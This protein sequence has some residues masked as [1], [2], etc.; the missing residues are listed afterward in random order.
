[1]CLDDM[2]DACSI[3]RII[4]RFI[5]VCDLEE[6]GFSNTDPK[7]RGR[8]SYSPN[9]LAKLFMF[10]YEEG[11]RS[12][13]R[14]EKACRTNTEV[15]W[16]VGGLAPD[17]KT[18]ADFRRDNTS[19]LTALFFEFNSFL[20]SAGLFGKRLVAVDGTK[21][22]ASNSKRRNISKKSLERRIEHHEAAAAEFFQKAQQEDDIE[23]ADGLFE[24]AAA[25]Q[26]KA[27]EAEG[28]LAEMDRDQVSEISLTDPDA[29]CMGKGRQGMHVA[30]NVQTAVDAKCHLIADL[31]VT[32]RADDH[33]QL[34]DMATRTQETMRK[35]DITF[36][37]DKGYYGIADLKACRNLGIDC[38]VAPQGKPGSANNSRYSIDNFT[39]DAQDD[40]YL[41][42][43]GERLTCKSKES[44]LAKVYSNK[45]ACAACEAQK[46]CKSANL[47]YRK[48]IRQPDSEVL[49]WADE[50]YYANTELYK[51]RQQLVEHPFGTV[52]RTMG[53]DHFLL[54][55]M[56]KVRCEAALLLTG[57]NLK[58]AMTELGFYGLMARLDEYAALIGA[59]NTL[60]S[61]I[62]ALTRLFHGVIGALRAAFQ[63]I[64][65]M[66]HRCPNAL[67]A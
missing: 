64:N 54:R 67:S 59:P 7:E 23:A 8:N 48:V 15:M 28:F 40:C 55:G 57:Y 21:I 22:K 10:C 16:L 45:N 49:E 30:Y 17:F 50:R 36:I 14:I 25:A 53:G 42:P 33:G 65:P 52:K 32:N 1:M 60:L 31:N 20:E 44:S 41:C 2:V 29:R 62:L 37:A 18:I 43:K 5:Q 34:S 39:Y 63:V 66:K 38:V 27:D 6:L 46:E 4:D 51:Q 56:E 11:I 58:R 13:R 47:E 61:S 9:T 26:A 19:A 3:V 35:H 24:K 12:S